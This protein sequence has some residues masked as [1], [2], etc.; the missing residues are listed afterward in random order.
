MNKTLVHSAIHIHT[1]RVITV[2]KYQNV[3]IIT[4]VHTVSFSW[5]QPQQRILKK[6][7]GELKQFSDMSLYWFRQVQVSD[8]SRF[9]MI[10]PHG[11]S[12]RRRPSTTPL[13]RRPPF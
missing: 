7:L 1:Y 3:S 4:F 6:S 8:S 10:Q 12:L 5:R 9:Y 11:V 2:V 13:R